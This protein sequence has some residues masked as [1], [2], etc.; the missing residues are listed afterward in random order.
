MKNN[1]QDK[2]KVIKHKTKLQPLEIVKKLEQRV[3]KI[4]NK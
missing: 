3:K 4:G 1:T 2:G